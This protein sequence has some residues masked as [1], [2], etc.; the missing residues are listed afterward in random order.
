MMLMLASAN[1]DDKVFERPDAF[2]ITRAPRNHMA[3]GYGPHICIG[4]HLARLEMINAMNALLDRLPRL[5]ADTDKPAA[6]VSGLSLR[7]PQHLYV[8]FD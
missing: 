4:Q 8:R 6:V 7:G 2:D 5:R 3:F 1:H